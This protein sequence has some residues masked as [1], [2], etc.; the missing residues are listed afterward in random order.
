[1]RVEVT[2]ADERLLASDYDGRTKRMADGADI[3][4]I[5]GHGR[6]AR[7]Q[8]ELLLHSDEWRPASAGLDGNGPRVAIFDACNLITPNDGDWAAPWMAAV[9]PNLRLVL[10]FASNATVSK[11]ASFRGEEFAERVARGDTIAGAWI[12]AVRSHDAHGRDRPVAIAFGSDDT[13]AKHLLGHGNLATVLSM[14]PLTS[15][16]VVRRQL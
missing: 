16:A 8:F 13:E 14:P 1:M 4:Y 10:G 12:A 6:Q 9:R 11:A 7:G 2:G 5:A 3:L 15:A